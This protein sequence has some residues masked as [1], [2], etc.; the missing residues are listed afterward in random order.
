MIQNGKGVHAKN[1]KE[2]D[3]KVSYSFSDGIAVFPKM[4]IPGCHSVIL[5]SRR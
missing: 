1:K 2:N 5:R 3:K 4:G